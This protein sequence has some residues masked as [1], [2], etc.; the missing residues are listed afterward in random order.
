M[1]AMTAGR[2]APQIGG[3]PGVDDRLTD[4]S[5][6]VE[7]A[8]LDGRWVAADDGA[9]R[10]VADPA[11]GSRIGAVPALGEAETVRAIAA[12]AAAWP[13]WRARTAR[14]RG[15][16][17]QRWAELMADHRE[18]LAILMTAEQGKPLAEARGEID[19]AASFLEWFA[20]EGRRAYGETVPTHLSDRRIL[21]TREPIGVTAAVTPWNFPSA[22][23]TR[24]A[25]AALAAGCPM[26]VRPATD[27]PYSALSLAVLAERAGIPGGA[28]QV[29]TGD[30]E[31][32][33]GTLTA[34]PAVRAI[35]FTGSTEIGR[36]LI[37]A[38]ADT[39][40]R[41]EMELG[42][43]APVIV[44]ADAD[45]DRAVA[46]AVATK[47]QTTGQDCLAANRILVAR[48][49]YDAFCRR[50]AEAAAAL[51]VG[52]GFDPASDLG[53]LMN[54]AAVEKCR[55]HVEDAVAKGARL[56]VGGTAPAHGTLFPATVLADMGPDMAIWREETFGPVAAIRSIADDAEALH[57]AND[58]D[59]GLAAY[60]FG[61][62]LSAVWRL[63]EGLEY[64][65]VAINTAKFTGAP[66]PFGGMKQ[67]GLGREGG[68]QGLDAFLETKYVCLGGIDA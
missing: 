1:A 58:S 4:R 40:K 60:V 3:R 61:R 67:S 64:G 39:V 12:A 33:V 30:P 2:T 48:P 50:F 6:R 22:M 63:A 5:L 41:V 26:I 19:Y 51:V 25:G 36:R 17:L 59:Y 16:L 9:V 66:V 27:T 54:A 43:H 15:R 56:L 49:L 20:E 31:P 23:I 55:R 68:R 18:D 57:L 21:V 65:M 37:R 53:P 44:R 13:A 29:L 62:D 11:D 47:F 7:Q 46:D 24:K 42:G 38:S 45:L 34:S 28:F 32:I 35:S 14:D 10:E 8:W 52:D